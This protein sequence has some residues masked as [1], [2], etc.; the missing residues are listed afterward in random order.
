ML[1]NCLIVGAG[2]FI[3][4]V[5][6]YL[7]GLLPCTPSNGFPLK[8]LLINLL[9]AL[10]I[11]FITALAARS[12]TMDPGIL[13]LIKVGICG[14]FTTFSTFAYETTELLQRG[15]LPAATAYICTSVV[16]SILAVFLGQ[17][18]AQYTA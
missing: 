14:G 7:I 10:L 4:S 2:G 17:Y 15:S 9:G 1:I 6:R 13:L 16:L 12:R 8:T 18:I 5:V 11:G 3:G